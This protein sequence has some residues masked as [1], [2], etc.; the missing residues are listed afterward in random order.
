MNA[1]SFYS[2][3]QTQ[4]LTRQAHQWTSLLAFSQERL[5]YR[6]ALELLPPS[7]RCLDWG[8]GNGHLSFFLAEH[9]FRTDAYALDEAPAMLRGRGGISFTR[10]HDRFTLPYPASSFDAVFGVGVLEHVTEHGGSETASLGELARVLKPGGLLFIF[11][12]PNRWS[13]IEIAKTCTW[14]LG[15]TSTREHV[16]RFTRR[17]FALL[18]AGTPFETVEQGRYHWLPRATLAR[19]PGLRDSAAFCA[20]IDRLDDALAAALKPVCQNWFFILRRR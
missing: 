7:A 9:G 20:A 3:I 13:W 17:D 2:L 11:H 10:G 5:V 14:R 8:C 1:R 15:L 6:K 16:R 18:L 19:L 4:G 12:L